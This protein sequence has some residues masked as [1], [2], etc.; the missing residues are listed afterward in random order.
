[1]TLLQLANFVRIAEMQSVSKA[2]AVVGVA[3]PALSRQVRNLEAELGTPLLERR[4]WGVTLTPAGEVL[5]AR[6]RRLLFEADDAR[7]AVRALASDPSGRVALG[8]PASICRAL[9]PPL[10]LAL[11]PEFPNLRPYLL[12]GFSASLH[13]RVLAG[14]LDLA[15][16]YDQRPMGPLTTAQLLSE[17]LML[18]GPP[19]GQIDAMGTPG[20][21]L[22]DRPLI[23]PARPNRLRLLIDEVLGL[24]RED[25]PS[26]LEVDAL[27]AI[28][29]MV[30]RGAGYT[31]LPY[32][33]VAAEVEG[34]ALA[35]GPLPGPPLTRTLL[36]ARPIDRPATAVVTAMEQTLRQ[37][38]NAL[39]PTLRWRPLARSPAGPLP[40][41]RPLDD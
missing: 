26:I 41:R 27:P 40:A 25:E 35:V 37:V 4:S 36:L 1:M 3:Q 39:A 9:L 14:D 33:A 17:D 10:A 11:R 19:N 29:G 12:D 31:V 22:A 2:A 6:A 34:G 13:A 18:V 8:V 21:R 32:S 15:I 5:L 30:E 23:L 7:D 20:E 16:L 38:I 28:I 24:R